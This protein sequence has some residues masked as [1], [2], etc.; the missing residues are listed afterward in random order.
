MGGPPRGKQHHHLLNNS[1]GGE[2]D[3]RVAI[4][5]VGIMGTGH[6]RCSGHCVEARNLLMDIHGDMLISR[7]VTLKRLACH[8]PCHRHGVGAKGRWC[9]TM[10]GVN[11]NQ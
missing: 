2:G 5:Y 4:V 9:A 3:G 8:R 6:A 1:T 10:N 7:C 11:S